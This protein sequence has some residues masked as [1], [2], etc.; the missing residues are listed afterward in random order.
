MR[1]WA[2]SLKLRLCSISHDRRF[3]PLIFDR[4]LVEWLRGELPA[5]DGGGA[6]GAAPPRHRFVVDVSAGERAW[7]G[8]CGRLALG[9]RDQNSVP[10]P[11][12][13]RYLYQ[14]VAAARV[15]WAEQRAALLDFH[16]WARAFHSG[17]EFALVRDVAE[18][19]RAAEA[20]GRRIRATAPAA[21]PAG[22][23]RKAL[24]ATSGAQ[25]ERAREMEAAHEA[26]ETAQCAK[27]VLQWLLAEGP[28]MRLDA[29][30]V[31]QRALFCPTGSRVHK[32]A[33][34]HHSKPGV[35]LLNPPTAWLAE[36]MSVAAPAAVE[37]VCLSPDGALVLAAAGSEGLVS[38]RQTGQLI[39]RLS[40][41]AAGGGEPRAVRACAWSGRVIAL[42]CEGGVVRLFDALA[43]M[44]VSAIEGAHSGDVV[45][46]SFADGGERL[47]SAGD[48]TV[49]VWRLGTGAGSAEPP[50][51]EA[52]L[53]GHAALVRAAVFSPDG[54]R[55]AS[56]AGEFAKSD[57]TVRV[58]D[59]ATATCL[60]TFSGHRGT[61]SCVAFSPDG[62]LLVSGSFDGTL[63]GWNPEQDGCTFCLVGHAG[64]VFSCCVVPAVSA[65]GAGTE[66]AIAT[67]GS[68]SVVVSTGDDRT[69]RVWNVSAAAT[70]RNSPEALAQALKLFAM[71]DRGNF[72][73]WGESGEK[74]S[75]ED[76]LTTYRLEIARAAGGRRHA[77]VYFR[78][79][80]DAGAAA[81]AQEEVFWEDPCVGVLSGHAGG[82]AGVCAD[83]Q[84]VV[85]GGRDKTLR[86]WSVAS[87]L[88]G[89]KQLDTGGSGR[90]HSAIV[91]SLCFSPDGASLVSGGWDQS[92]VVSDGA[93]GAP[94][95]APIA[96]APAEVNAV[97]WGPGGRLIAAGTG[98]LAA[99]AANAI[100][101]YKD[102]GGDAGWA[103]VAVLSGH[104][105]PVTSLCFAGPRGDAVVSGCWDH[106]V[107]AW[108]WRAG[109]AAGEEKAAG[110]LLWTVEAH[111]AAVNAVQ[112]SPDRRTLL[113][114]GDTTVKLWRRQNATGGSVDAADAG[115]ATGGPAPSCWR[116]LKAS[117]RDRALSAAFSSD[118]VLVLSTARDNLIRLWSVE[119]GACL[120]LF[121]ARSPGNV[122][123]CCW[124]GAG[125]GA[126]VVGF[127]SGVVELWAKEEG[128]AASAPAPQSGAGERSSSLQFR[129]VG[130][131]TAINSGPVTAIAAVVADITDSGN[132]A[133]QTAAPQQM[134]NGGDAKTS[135]AVLP[136]QGKKQNG[137]TAASE[138]GALPRQ[139][140]AAAL[141]LS[142]AVP[143][144]P[145]RIA[146]G[147]QE[148]AVRLIQ[149]DGWT[150]AAD[151]R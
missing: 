95:G 140:R 6:Q 74:A 70:A 31:V 2:V 114:L 101:V 139:Q 90:H 151:R 43:G 62:A 82:V 63:R 33:L 141:P 113:T 105:E 78:R 138:G 133:A 68:S 81:A 58:W 11:Y 16:F 5:G 96:D 53:T 30:T 97:A 132:E 55:V 121:G 115:V 130:A 122:A 66:A 48:R 22:S 89:V 73:A 40:S 134:A 26:S 14:H 54:K 106:E 49:K 150:V 143:S 47:C 131:V 99:G 67:A 116:E 85:S 61:V 102:R 34:A 88:D 149:W 15:T 112:A 120:Q 51:C 126:I 20:E 27:E 110:G 104:R 83:G 91:S 25:Q 118:G 32:A 80:Q 136:V 144:P 117:G 10:E 103:R 56:G 146:V 44:A 77:T 50:V 65:D 148:G 128:G 37:A 64:P 38:D 19:Q 4:S 92:V 41:E 60:R 124:G 17:L 75:P 46:C 86:A 36:R 24:G 1:V 52:T 7:A 109:A 145:L 119:T 87:L 45:A 94:V 108:D 129:R 23:D 29:G 18:V 123:G 8:Y 71:V 93:T 21:A 111:S 98:R 12:A 127:T 125:D 137:S 79:K 142:A 72:Q 42:T 9:Q 57:N 76:E 28:V 3:L 59:A 107:R 39:A 69:L 13:M 147:S 100:L 35:R 84:G 135:G